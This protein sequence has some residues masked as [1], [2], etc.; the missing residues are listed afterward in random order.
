[1]SIE[2]KPIASS[3]RGNAYLVTDGKTPLLLECGIS[4]KKIMKATDFSLYDVCGCLISHEHGDHSKY[5]RE[6]MKI[7]IDCYAS[8]GTFSKL[9]DLNGHRMH[10]IEALKQFQVGSWAI[11]PFNTVHDCEEPLG[12]LM[13]SGAEKLLFATDTAF[14]KYKFKGL[15][16]VMI[17]CNNDIEIVNKNVANGSITMAQKNRLIESHF[18]ID[19]VRDFIRA[20]D[21]SNVKEIWLLHLSDR[22][23]DAS[24]F[25]KE[26]KALTGVPVFIAQA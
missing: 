6:I 24:E 1:M 19:N 12:F 14:V 23:S 4:L 18:S 5:I 3:S 22:N 25:E 21:M 13:Q 15:T 11:L 9:T 16:H 10:K 8:G 20:N 2:I 26:I 7:G 17:E